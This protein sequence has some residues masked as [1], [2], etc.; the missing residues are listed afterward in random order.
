MIP[1][2]D[3]MLTMLPRWRST[4]CAPTAWDIRHSAVRFV[5]MT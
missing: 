5:S 3:P 2:I 1:D 4:M